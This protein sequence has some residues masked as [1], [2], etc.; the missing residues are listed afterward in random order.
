MSPEDKIVY[1]SG[2]LWIDGGRRGDEVDGR[3]GRLGVSEGRRI[4]GRVRPEREGEQ[5]TVS[6]VEVPPKH[7]KPN[8]DGQR[9]KIQLACGILNTMTSLGIPDSYRVA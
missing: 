1:A 4:E 8:L 7:A 6:G 2:R 5:A 9:A 3:C